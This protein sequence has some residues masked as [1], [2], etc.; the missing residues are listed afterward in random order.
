MDYPVL[1]GCGLTSLDAAKILPL[2]LP[3][4]QRGCK[5]S[6]NLLPNPQGSHLYQL[7][8]TLNILSSTLV[9]TQ[10]SMRAL[11]KPW[12]VQE[13]EKKESSIP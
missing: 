4:C 2:V 11:F 6:T 3:V 5:Q 12:V 9:E 7:W 8:L 13:K 10:V 1:A